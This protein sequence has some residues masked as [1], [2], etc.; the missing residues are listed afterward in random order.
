MLSK[1]PIKSYGPNN[2]ILERPDE[3]HKEG[4]ESGLNS[5]YPIEIQPDQHMQ[6]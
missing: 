1:S 5:Q 3:E 6:P 4:M 2:P